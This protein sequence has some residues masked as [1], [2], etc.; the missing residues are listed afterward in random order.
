MAYYDS[1]G[2]LAFNKDYFDVNK[3]NSAYDH[4]VETGFHPSRGNKT[5][6]EATMSHELGHR[7]T[8]EIA[9]N[10]GLK[11]WQIDKVSNDIVRQASRN[12]GYGNATRKF[13]SQISGYA[14]KGG[15]AEA[16]A[17]AFADVYCNGSKAKGE[18]K[19][20]VDILNSYLKK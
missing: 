8:D 13:I 11:G 5:G 9:K 3:M 14:K 2:N 1:D 12:A 7:L 4:C 16:V 18:S 20:I 6:I 15:N 10:Q 17:E 19:A